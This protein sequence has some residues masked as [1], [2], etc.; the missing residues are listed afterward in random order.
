MQVEQFG[1][2]KFRVQHRKLILEIERSSGYIEQG[3]AIVLYDSD[4][5]YLGL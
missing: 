4:L 3:I 2:S 1:K 5:N